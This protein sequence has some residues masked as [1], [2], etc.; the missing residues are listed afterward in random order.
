MK[1]LK[2]QVYTDYAI[3]PWSFYRQETNEFSFS[4]WPHKLSVG[5]FFPRGVERLIISKEDENNKQKTYYSPYYRQGF[6]VVV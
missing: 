1:K 3:K 6:R 4:L 2:I 5:G